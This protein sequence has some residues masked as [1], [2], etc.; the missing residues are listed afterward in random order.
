[1]LDVRDD[2]PVDHVDLG[3][4]A[5]PGAVRALPSPPQEIPATRWLSSEVVSLL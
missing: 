1:M 3:G 2:P 5:L 4:P